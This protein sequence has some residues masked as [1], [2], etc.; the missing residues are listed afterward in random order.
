MTEKLSHHTP[1]WVVDEV[2][3][4]GAHEARRDATKAGM[5]SAKRTLALLMRVAFSMVSPERKWP[6]LRK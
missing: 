1:A 5:Y 2:L 3:V 4:V 6:A